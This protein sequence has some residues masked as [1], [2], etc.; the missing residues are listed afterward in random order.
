MNWPPTDLL[1]RI[2]PHPLTYVSYFRAFPWLIRYFTGE[3]PGIVR[4]KASSDPDEE[5]A[6]EAGVSLVKLTAR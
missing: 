5:V 6:R 4:R 2:Q 1:G 3:V